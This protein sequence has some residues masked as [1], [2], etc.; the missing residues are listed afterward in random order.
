MDNTTPMI[1]IVEI[2]RGATTEEMEA[3]L[4]KPCEAGYRFVKLIWPRAVFKRCAIRG[5]KEE[6]EAAREIVLQHPDLSLRALE[7]LLKGAGIRRGLDWCRK[8]RV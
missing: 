6:D 5:R 7:K 3:L 8:N 4:N 1:R 2:P